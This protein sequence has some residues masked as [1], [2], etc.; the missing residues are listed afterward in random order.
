MINKLVRNR[1]PMLH[2]IGREL[3]AGRIGQTANAAGEGSKGDEI[4]RSHLAE[5]SPSGDE[6]DSQLGDLPRT[7]RSPAVT[8]Y[9]ENRRKPRPALASPRDKR[10]ATR[11]GIE[12]ITDHT[13]S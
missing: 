3:H 10:V 12:Q 9:S 8:C 1:L 6:E 4:A 5:F 7:K 13:L 2:E 11:F